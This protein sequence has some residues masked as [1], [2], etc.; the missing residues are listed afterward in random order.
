MQD[1]VLSGLDDDIWSQETV[2]AVIAAKAEKRATKGLTLNCYSLDV[3]AREDENEKFN[4]E[5]INA[6]ADSIYERAQTLADGEIFRFQV[7]V[8]VNNV[9]WTAVDME[10]SNN[11]VKALNL[12]AMGD[13]SGISAAEAMFHQLADKYPNSNDAAAAD[14]FKFT[15]LKLKIIDGTYD[16]TQGIQYDNNSCSRFT[17]DHL[18]HLANIDTFRALNADQA[19]RKY[20]IIE[21][22]RK[23]R[24]VQSFDSSTMPKEFSFL[25]RD[26]Q[27]KT[28]FASLPDNI[29]QQVVNKKGQT[30]AQSEAAHTQ[31]IQIK[32]EGK[33]NNQAIY[34]K[35]AG[36]AVDARA[37]ATATDHQALLD[38][39]DLLNAL[40]NNTFLQ[41]HNF[42]KQSIT[43]NLIDEAKTIKSAKSI[44]SLSDIYHHFRDTLSI[45]RAEKKLASNNEED[46]LA[47]LAKLKSTTPIHKEQL[48]QAKENF[49]KQNEKQGNTEERDDMARRL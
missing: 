38:N 37:L 12:D 41:G 8:K 31:T 29:K 21:Q 42:C 22:D 24:I 33:L 28:S 10:V 3:G 34:N 4:E 40:D 35:K 49:N 44:G 11:S 9:H 39:R 27:S 14:N 5:H 19:F 36:F 2:N 47:H 30:L 23:H 16:K 25:Y 20:N 18:F 43:R 15:W 7:A 1:E 6:F 26:T 46:A 48:A 32:G 13:E 17:L 45:Y